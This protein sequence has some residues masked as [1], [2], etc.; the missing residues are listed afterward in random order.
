MSGDKKSYKVFI[1]STYLDNAE[2]RRIVEDAVIRADMQPI[3]MERFTA[4]A[5]P[6]VGECERYARDC[7]IYV[8]IIAH[9][10]GWIPD[11]KQVSITELEYDAAKEAE[12]P[13]LMFEMDGSVPVD[14]QKD[15]DPLPD[16]WDKQKKLD[17]FKAKYRK[18]QMPTP[19]TDTSLGTKVLHALNLRRDQQEGK[20]PAA[21]RRKP[22]DGAVSQELDRYRRA[23]KSLH[24]TLPLAGFKTKLRVPIALEEL[25]VPLQAHVDLRASGDA[26]FADAR[27]GEERLKSAHGALDIALIDAFREAAKCRRRGLVILG[28]PGSGKTTHLKR[29]LLWCLRQG[30]EEMGL[31]P[32]SLPVFLP[33]RDLRDL[34]KG[35]HGFIEQTLDNPHLRMPEGF[36]ARLLARGRLLLLFDGLDEVSDPKDR[37]RVARWIEQAAQ[38]RPSCTAVV[39]CRFAGYDK[40]ARLGTEFLELHLRPLTR[41]QSETFIGNWYRTVE[42]GLAPD[43]AQG[44]ITAQQRADDLI[45][46]LRAPNFRS[47]RMVEMTRNPLLLA[48]LC[49][50]HRDRG[51]LPRG[52][53]Q[54]YDECIEVLLERWREGKALAINVSAEVGRR[55]LQ[56]AALWLHAE[57]GRTRA[58]AH[59]LAPILGPALKATQ[60][61]DGDAATFLRTV[62]DESGLL[63]GWGPDHFGFMHLGFQE[64]LAACELRRLAF[65]GDKDA[66]LKDLAS[67]YG[68]SWWQEMILMLLAQG[69]PSL[70]TPFMQQALRHPCFGAATELLGLILEEAAEVSVRPFVELLQ[71][72]PGEDPAHWARQLG[73]L[74]VLERL[75]ADVEFNTLVKSLRQ[76]PLGEVQA[77]AQARAQAAIRPTRVTQQGGVELV[78]IPGGTCHMGSPASDPQALNY[79]RPAHDVEVRAFYLGRHPVTNEEY[80]RFLKAHPDVEEPSYWGDRQF[81]QARQPVVGVSWEDAQRFAEW[82]G[83]RLPTEAEW[84]YAARAGTA[85][86]YWWGDEVGKNNA[87]CHGCGSQWDGKQTAPVGSFEP[88]AF[89]LHDMLGNVWEWVEDCWHGSYKGAPT[90]GSAWGKQQG[91]DCAWRVVRGGSWDSD[92]R[93]IRSAIRFGYT[94]D[95]RIEDAGFRLAQDI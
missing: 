72:P 15:F 6:T 27:E 93:G 80:G 54:L 37:A 42:T 38:A 46:R 4:S 85:T 32:E 76:H 62:R 24:E 91:G 75:G 92:P 51:A 58:S 69:N 90:D 30:P 57:E 31:A 64:Y 35:I 9:P 13:R 94:P 56:P 67:H 53:H 36:G 34:S 82:A 60:W 16:R 11:G 84:E 89:G 2:R 86:R 47:A 28:D 65:A 83:G 61:C 33:L 23:A 18:D 73:A 44:A 79:E 5:H 88:N 40:A 68:E 81:N 39:T 45:E 7:D 26:I 1:S 3:G 63:T 87:N 8:G 21:D 66:V 52:R 49:L 41:E 70:F 77:L 20:R 14:M 95:P 78:L 74:H 50:V 55:V 59:D 19:F 29:L 22:D 43:P 71:Q 12:R 17:D 48:N 10:Y 25:Y